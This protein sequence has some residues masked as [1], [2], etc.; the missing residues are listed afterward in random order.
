MSKKEIKIFDFDEEGFKGIPVGNQLKMLGLGC[1]MLYM[2]LEEDD[3]ESSWIWLNKSSEMF[4][5]S[6]AFNAI[7]SCVAQNISKRNNKNEYYYQKLFN[8]VVN[9]LLKGSNPIYVKTNGKDIPDSFVDVNGET[10]PVEVKLGNFDK[11]AKRQLERYID[12]Y[13][14]CSGIAVGRELTTELPENMMFFSLKELEE[15]REK[16]DFEKTYRKGNKHEN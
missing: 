2:A 5:G 14:C 4:F 8:R 16:M 6:T 12:S 9:R 15:E 10:M 13:G 7:R 3:E 11:K 1:Y